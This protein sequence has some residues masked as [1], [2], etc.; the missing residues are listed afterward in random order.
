MIFADIEPRRPILSMSP[1]AWDEVGSPTRQWSSR[2]PAVSIQSRM[3]IVPSVASSSSSPVIS[4]ATEPCGG[5]SAT[6]S[7]AAATKAATP[8]FMSAAPRP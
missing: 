2:S 3:A 7:I 1:I 5:V 8:D 6:N 4:S